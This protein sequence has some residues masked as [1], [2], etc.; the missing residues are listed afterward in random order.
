[1]PFGDSPSPIDN[2]HIAE[3][4][5]LDIISRSD[6]YLYITTPYLIVDTNITEALK[7]AVKR[8]VDVRIIIPQIPDKKAVYTMTKNTCA[9][10]YKAG[11]KIYAYKDGFIHSKTFLSDGEIG[12]IGTVNL[13]Y[14]SLVHHFECATV[15]CKTNSLIDLYEDFLDLFDYQ[16]VKCGEKEL[17]LNWFERLIKSVI[18]IIAPLM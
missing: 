13:D 10:L 7:T 4:V 15:L 16:S 1:M 5:Y 17:R 11:V 14:R 18:S 3:N 12:V 9:D 2:D 8:G 6:K